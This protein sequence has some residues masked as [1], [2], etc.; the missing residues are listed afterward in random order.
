[1]NLPSGLFEI[2]V[3]FIFINFFGHRMLTRALR[4]IRYAAVYNSTLPITLTEAVGEQTRRGDAH[5]IYPCNLRTGLTKQTADTAR[6]KELRLGS[7][8]VAFER[9]CWHTAWITHTDR[10]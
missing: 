10:A 6:E 1:M 7:G 4:T 3:L 9:L 2:S 8:R 5:R